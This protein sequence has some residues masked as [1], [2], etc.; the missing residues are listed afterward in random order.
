MKPKE[1]KSHQR[2]EG[3]K[4]YNTSNSCRRLAGKHPESPNP[5]IKF[6]PSLYISLFHCNGFNKKKR[7]QEDEGRRLGKGSDN[8]VVATLLGRRQ[9]RN[10][11]GGDGGKEEG[12]EEMVCVCVVNIGREERGKVI[13]KREKGKIT[14]LGPNDYEMRY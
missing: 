9:W 5:S 8:L 7:R 2:R 14:F 13:R 10:K 11:E 3:R 1:I 6:A 4:A 12:E